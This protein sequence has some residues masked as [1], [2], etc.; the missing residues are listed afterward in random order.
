[1]A[2][3][4]LFDGLKQ[5]LDG[6]YTQWNATEWQPL[7]GTVRIGQQNDQDSCGVCVLNAMD[8]AMKRAALFKSE[9]MHLIRM[10]LFTKVVSYLVDYVCIPFL[11]H[12][13]FRV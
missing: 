8:F 3:T 4:P 1:M 5:W 12:L 2:L 13:L 10:D 7:E 6:W 9:T 11:V